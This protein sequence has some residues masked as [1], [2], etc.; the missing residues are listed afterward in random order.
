MG[1]SGIRRV[2]IGTASCFAFAAG[3]AAPSAPVPPGQDTFHPPAARPLAERSGTEGDQYGIKPPAAG[4]PAAAWQGPGT[5]DKATCGHAAC[6]PGGTLHPAIKG[7]DQATCGHKGCHAP[8]EGR[9]PL[10]RT[11]CGH[12]GCHTPLDGSGKTP[13]R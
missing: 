1:G 7:T 13:G 8:R 9:S 12:V 2:A 4:A 6:H 11:N 3:C 10:D 5:G